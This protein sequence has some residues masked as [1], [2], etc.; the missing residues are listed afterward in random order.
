MPFFLLP[1][2]RAFDMVSH[3]ILVSKLEGKGFDGWTTVDKKLPGWLLPENSI[4]QLYVQWWMVSLRGP[5][6]GQLCLASSSMT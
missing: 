6:W 4:Q 2:D 1:L 5:Y 3:K